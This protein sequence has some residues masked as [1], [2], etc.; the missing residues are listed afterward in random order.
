MANKISTL[1]LIL[2]LCSCLPLPSRKPPPTVRHD[3]NEDSQTKAYTFVPIVYDKFESD[4]RVLKVGMWALYKVKEK[5]AVYDFKVA[6]VSTEGSNFWVETTKVEQVGDNVSTKV[7]AILV[8][9][10]SKAIVAFYKEDSGPVVGQSI[11]PQPQEVQVE[12]PKIEKRVVTEQ[13]AKCQAG[14]FAA[15]LQ[16]YTITQED[17]SQTTEKKFISKA[18]PPLYEGGL[19]ISDNMELVAFGSDAKPSVDIPRK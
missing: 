15:D 2:T 12:W 5:E 16:I 6:V 8:T 1:L 11:E 14:E 7:S 18:V 9:P 4:T 3:T 17:G 10:D 19:V 13:K